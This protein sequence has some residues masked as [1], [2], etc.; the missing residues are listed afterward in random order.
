VNGVQA[1][2]G[3][4]YL[5]PRLD[6]QFDVVGDTTPSAVSNSQWHY[7]TDVREFIEDQPLYRGNVVVEL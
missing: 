4:S 2:Q 7:G 6:N 3:K 1:Y 5:N